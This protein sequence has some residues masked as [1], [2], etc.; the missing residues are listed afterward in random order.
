[1]AKPALAK[2]VR[3]RAAA[4]KSP[5]RLSSPFQIF[6]GGGVNGPNAGIFRAIEA[7]IAFLDG[8]SR[9]ENACCDFFP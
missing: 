1:M 8:N 6:L 7:A 2:K 9:Y 4:S 3:A 5:M